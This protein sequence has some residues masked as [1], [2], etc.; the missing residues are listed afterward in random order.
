MNPIRE[1]MCKLYTLSEQMN[2]PSLNEYESEFFQRK[3]L[4]KKIYLLQQMGLDLSYFF[5]WFAYG[6]YSED[7]TLDLKQVIRRRMKNRPPVNYDKV[8]TGHEQ[9]ISKLN[10]IEKELNE[11]D[12]NKLDL[13]YE[14]IASFIFLYTHFPNRYKKENDGDIDWRAIFKNIISVKPDLKQ[15]IKMNEDRLFS[16]IK[17]YFLVS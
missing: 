15:I 7:L 2:F 8:L 4:Q 11:I 12:R 5:G 6:P 9:K 3:I 17:K 16:I 10:K 13:L 1:R 14:I